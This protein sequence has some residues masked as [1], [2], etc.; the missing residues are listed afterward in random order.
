MQTPNFPQSQTAHQNRLLASLPHEDYERLRPRLEPVALQ[1]KHTL[2]KANAPIEFV[3]FIETGV[4]S[5]VNTMTNGDAAEVG[6]IGNEGMVGLPV[7]FGDHQAPTAAYVQVPGAG[8]RMKAKFFH[9]QMAQNASLRTA[10]LHYAHAFLNQVAQ[11]AACNIFHTLEQRCCRWLLMTHD[12][13]QSDEF[14]LTQKF[15]A[16]MLGVRRAGVANA[17]SALQRAG[18]IKYTRGRVTILDRAGLLA[19]S[20]ECYG[21]SKREFD[22]LLGEAPKTTS[23]H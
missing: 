23:R 15:L 18:L 2:Y 20:C 1:T 3:H 19:C 17:A 8:S 10:M 11:S 22:R 16:M 14:M 7:V 21:V 6:T 4:G 13:M 12:R 5:L 9:E